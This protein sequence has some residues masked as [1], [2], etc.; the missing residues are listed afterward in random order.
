M[1]EETCLS[2]KCNL[3]SFNRCHSPAQYASIIAATIASLNQNINR[4]L[5]GVIKPILTPPPVREKRY[6]H[7]QSPQKMTGME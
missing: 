6:Q 7:F 2:Y 3:H 1:H 4:K 5:F